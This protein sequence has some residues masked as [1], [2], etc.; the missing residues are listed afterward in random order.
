MLDELLAGFSTTI[1][2]WRLALNLVTGVFM[3]YFVSILYH[4]SDPKADRRLSRL[5]PFLAAV[6]TL[7]GT[8]IA[9]SLGIAIGLVGALSVVRFRTVVQNLDQMAFLFRAVAVGLAGSSGQFFLGIIVLLFFA[10]F[11]GFRAWRRSKAG[12]NIQVVLRGAPQSMATALQ[13]IESHFPKHKFEGL[14]QNSKSTHWRISLTVQHHREI[15]KL[16]SQLSQL[17]DLSFSLS[18]EDAMA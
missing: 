7:A 18:S 16:L 3:G 6:M 4:V 9:S 8:L 15:L 10:L 11:H 17:P 14:K 2:P 1:D 13:H 5:F 12:S